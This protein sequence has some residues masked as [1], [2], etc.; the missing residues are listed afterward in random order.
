MVDASGEGFDMCNQEQSIAVL[1]VQAPAITGIEIP[2][3]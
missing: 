2:N 1:T 3:L